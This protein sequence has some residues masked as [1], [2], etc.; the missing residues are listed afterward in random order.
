MAYDYFSHV[1]Y[2]QVFYRTDGGW[3]SVVASMAG[4]S[5]LASIPAHDWDNTVQYY[6]VMQDTFGLQ[7]T[8]DNSGL[9]YSYDIVD[10]VEPYVQI[11]HVTTSSKGIQSVD[12][13]A[14]DPGSDIAY[15]EL[16][17][18]GEL[19]A[20]LTT[21]PYNVTYSE[22]FEQI[23]GTRTLIA[24]AVDNAGNEMIHEVVLGV[25][26]PSAFVAFFQTWGTLFGAGV[27]GVAWGVVAIVQAVKKS[28]T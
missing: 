19:V 4:M 2:V 22:D 17:D 8:A 6:I 18:T 5:F 27:V 26:L 9:Y 15:V 1:S 3:S 24:R 14:Y 13:E 11:L 23:D 21:T 12:I 16:Y 10:N 20:N 25:D 28:K 7:S